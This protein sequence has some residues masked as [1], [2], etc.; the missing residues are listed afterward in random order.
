MR[1]LP[2]IVPIATIS[3][4]TDGCRVVTEADAQEATLLY[5]IGDVSGVRTL[6]PIEFMDFAQI[7]RIEKDLE[8][9]ASPHSGG[10]EGLCEDVV[11]I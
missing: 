7:G 4:T 11:L 9:H 5:K 6:E 2:T 8:A 10:A 3:K 1:K